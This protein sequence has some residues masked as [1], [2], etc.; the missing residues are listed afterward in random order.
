MKIS[1][2]LLVLVPAAIV[3]LGLFV[4]KRL[5]RL[6]D[7]RFT[8]T[9]GGAEA[10]DFEVT[11]TDGRTVS[12]NSLLEGKEVL[13]V[14]LLATWCGPCEKEFPEMDKVYQKY[15]DLMGM[16]AVNPDALD[17]EKAVQ[18]YA[19]KHHFSFPRSG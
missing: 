14:V 2:F 7:I 15:S 3:S 19:E 5:E 11:T 17:D 10:P 12:M 4:R 18:E 6:K 9:L 16:I 1:K 13:A 8:D